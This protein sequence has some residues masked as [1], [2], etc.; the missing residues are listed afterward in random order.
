MVSDDLRKTLAGLARRK[1][2]RT[3]GRSSQ[4]PCDW[5]PGSVMHPV[6]G[7]YFTEDGAWEYIAELLEGGHAAA[8]VELQ[9]PPGAQALVFLVELVA[10]Q[11]ALYIKIHIGANRIIGRSFHISYL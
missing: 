3:A 9:V 2:R 1:D 6:H 11:P 4:Y 10:G 7:M 5:R 8:E